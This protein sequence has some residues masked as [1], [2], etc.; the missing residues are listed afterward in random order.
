MDTSDLRKTL[1][2][3][4][5]RLLNAAP[6]LCEKYPAAEG[7]TPIKT[8]LV[9][10]FLND[11][12][13][14]P[15]LE[16]ADPTQPEKQFFEKYRRHITRARAAAQEANEAV[17]A[18]R[19]IKSEAEQ[20]DVHDEPQF[21]TTT[22]WKDA[23]ETVFAIIAEVPPSRIFK[24]LSKDGKPLLPQIDGV[25]TIAKKY[26]VLKKLNAAF[27]PLLMGYITNQSL[28]GAVA[29]KSA[30]WLMIGMATKNE[31]VYQEAFKHLCGSYPARQGDMNA[32]G[33]PEDVVATVKHRSRELRYQRMSV[34][35]ELLTLTI[36]P[37]LN[38]MKKR[39]NGKSSKLNDEMIE[40][41]PDSIATLTRSRFRDYISDQLTLLESPADGDG[42]ED[43]ESTSKPT[44]AGFYHTI[45]MGGD[46]YL[47]ADELVKTWHQSLPYDET[48]IR[49]MLK[50]LKV[51]ASQIVAP[52][53]HSTLHYEQKGVLK[54]LT[55]IEV[56]ADDIPWKDDEDVEMED[57]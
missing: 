54:Y 34:D 31:M 5:G 50:R 57:G 1:L 24:M 25:I 51:E 40:F 10:K 15:E 16:R 45:L 47:P 43:D 53:T 23:F 2:I 3:P 38:S 20:N 30:S 48:A 6:S 44:L 29:D 49:E 33:V 19:N 42:D 36:K 52:L 26:E 7:E 56:G 12:A 35:Q 4:Y 55:C 14:M 22:D 18:G 17:K 28:W 39:S 27:C 46:G 13:Q 41:R 37:Q 9:L 21:N 32:A 8:I 11:E